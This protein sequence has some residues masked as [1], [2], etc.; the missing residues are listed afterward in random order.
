M[1]TMKR[2][3]I[4]LF[5]GILLSQQ[6]SAKQQ[7]MEVEALS[8]VKQADGSI[9]YTGKIKYPERACNFAGAFPYALKYSKIN[10]KFD[11]YFSLKF[12]ASSPKEPA[13]KT[14]PG[15]RVG[16]PLVQADGNSYLTLKLTFTPKEGGAYQ[17]N[18]IPPGE[19]PL[20][21]QLNVYCYFT[22]S[23]AEFG[24]F[25]GVTLGTANTVVLDETCELNL[26]ADRAVK[27]KEVFLQN[28]KTSPQVYGGDF[29]I[30]LNCR[31]ATVNRAYISYSDGVTPTTTGNT[32]TTDTSIAGS[33]QNVGLK[34][35]DQANPGTPLSY[36]PA[37]TT[38][39]I[40]PANATPSIPIFADNIRRSNLQTKTYKVYYTQ[41]G[42]T[43]TAGSV[44]GRLKYNLYYR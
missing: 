25:G 37:P 41:S 34:I 32:L 2:I 19:N 22:G 28:V 30:Q 4:G 38:Q 43:P 1:Q 23:G 15:N 3:I 31:N 13:F 6:A 21:G 7:F 10:P 17:E 18:I 29:A 36:G 24:R 9:I 33:A 44:T 39:F 8:G 12:E 42:G 20:E 27:L 11:P 14:I 16:R 5:V 26:A 35:Y 40:V